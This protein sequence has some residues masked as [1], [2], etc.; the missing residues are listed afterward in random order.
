MPSLWNYAL[1]FHR[2]FAESPSFRDWP[3]CQWLYLEQMNGRCWPVKFMIGGDQWDTCPCTSLPHAQFQKQVLPPNWNK[4]GISYVVL[5]APSALL[6]RNETKR[7]WDLGVRRN[8]SGGTFL[9]LHLVLWDVSVVSLCTCSG[10]SDDDQLGDWE[11]Q[12]A[13]KV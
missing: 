13:K 8:T 1:L 3:W 6:T 9:L 2:K 12:K 11:V 4:V 5:G 10:A 7:K